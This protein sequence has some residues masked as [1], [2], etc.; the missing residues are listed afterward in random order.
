MTFPILGGN[1]AVGGY[2]IDNSLRFNDNDSAYLSRT[3][4][5]TTNRRTWTWSSWVKVSRGDINLGLFNVNNPS[6]N[7]IRLNLFSGKLN[8]TSYIGG[9]RQY[10]VRTEA[11]YRD[12]SAWYH[13]VV[14]F[15][16]TQATASNRVKFYVN[17]ELIT[18]F[19][20]SDYPTLNYDDYVNT[21]NPFVIGYGDNSPAYYFD[22]YMA[23]CHFID[24]TAKSPT[25]FGE[26]DEDSGIWKPIEYTGSYGTNGFYLDFENSGSLGADQSG[27]GNNFTPT[28]LASTDQTTDTPT[29][30]F[31]TFNP[32]ARNNGNTY[33][34][35]NTVYDYS[36]N[37]M[38][39]GVATMGVSSGKWYAEFQKS[40]ATTIHLFGVVA[41]N[42]VSDGR[43]VTDTS[44]N[45]DYGRGHT[46]T[47]YLQSFNSSQDIY[48][49]GSDTGTNVDFTSTTDDIIMV[50][51]DV[52]TKKIWFGKNGTWSSSGNPAT[53]SNPSH[54]YS[55][56]GEAPFY[57]SVGTENTSPIRANF[58]NPSF[59]ISSGNTDDNGYGNFEYAPPSGYLALCT[60]NLATELSPTIDDGSQYFNTV[61]YTGNVTA[62]SITGVGFQPD[63][64]WFKKRSS[65]AQNHTVYDSTRGTNKILFPDAT[66]AEA[67][68]SSQVT[69]FDSDGF[70]LGTGTLTNYNAGTYVAWNWKA[71]GGT[72]SSNTD[73]SITSTVQANTTAGFSIVTFTGTGLDATV[74]HGLNVAPD[75]VI[76]KSRDAV[77][78]WPV[79]HRS[80][81]GDDSLKLNLTD[82]TTT[83]LDCWNDLDPTSTVVHLGTTGGSNV[84]GENAVMY[85]FH[86][87]EGYSKFGS[88]TGNGSTDGTFV[89]TGFRPAWIMVKR[90]DSANNW[91]IVDA[92]RDTIN[93]MSKYVNAN[94]SDAEA[95]YNF[96]D[97]TSNGF[98]IRNTGSSFNTGTMIYM[99]FAEH[100]FVSSTGIPV[101]AR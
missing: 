21:T 71:N 26:F 61:L 3:P 45:N 64:I 44:G 14:S 25:D 49:D 74:G 52:D 57:F 10:Y 72:T 91:N 92:K 80:L 12:V 46:G 50:A 32:L 19:T 5:S 93:V 41:D 2:S 75:M 8:L 81:G 99:A 60:Q 28:N 23:E 69:S 17:G 38:R 98:K 7:Q 33:T 47:L 66:D 82:A 59:S 76:V 54:T 96:W 90:T 9:T 42:F 31:A 67:T 22:G 95:S 29:N 97:F 73:G 6:N 51:F 79:Y 43:T 20:N 11:I 70:S 84:S 68:N 4:S 65:P 101:T 37:F 36:N 63:W 18:N 40:D 53:G 39:N 48:Q 86:S 34:E 87:V 1:S 55:G 27:N 85:C 77:R 88:Y 58:G 15:D 100:P 35:G 24:G 62:R 83:S 13:F 89:Y 56:T 78:N 30:N 16:T 94:S